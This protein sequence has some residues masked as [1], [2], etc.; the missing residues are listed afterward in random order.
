MVFTYPQKI[1]FKHCDPAGIVFYPRYFEMINDCVEAFFAQIGFP[2]ETLHKTASVPTAEI[3]T[4][5]TAPSRHGDHLILTLEATRLGRSSLGLEITASAGTEARF[6][7]TST[8][9]LVD[10]TGRP[11]RWPDPMRA[12]LTPYIRSRP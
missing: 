7:C 3:S 8:L 9:V 2:F 6:A 12:A 4:R 10:A 1:L 11:L 5:F